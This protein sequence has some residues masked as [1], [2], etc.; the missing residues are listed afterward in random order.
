MQA[1]DAHPHD[2]AA[3]GPLLDLLLGVERPLL[4]PRRVRGID[5]DDDVAGLAVTPD[6]EH[7]TKE[8]TRVEVRRDAKTSCLADLEVADAIE[9]EK[10][11][12][13]N[14][15]NQPRF[16]SSGFANCPP[17]RRRAP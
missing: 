16:F 12:P 6:A 5:L 10:D 4:H 17:P 14:E 8:R 15:V 2:E 13:A 11:A 3:V 7:I 9:R 1:G